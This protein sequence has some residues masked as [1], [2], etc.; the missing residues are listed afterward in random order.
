MQRIVCPYLEPQVIC[1]LF[2][3][4]VKKDMF[5][6]FFLLTIIELYT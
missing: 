5:P 2:Q 6:I 1:A 4:A 3:T